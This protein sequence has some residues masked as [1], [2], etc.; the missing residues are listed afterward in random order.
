MSKIIWCDNGA[1]HLK[2]IRTCNALNCY[3]YSELYVLTWTAPDYT[4][5]NVRFMLNMLQV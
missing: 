2:R 4:V 3:T 1:L 5:Y